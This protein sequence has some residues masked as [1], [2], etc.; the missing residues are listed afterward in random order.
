MYILYRVQGMKVGMSGERGEG[1]KMRRT[2]GNGS[3]E[4][5]AQ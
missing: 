4:M 1:R 2:T 3:R 5:G